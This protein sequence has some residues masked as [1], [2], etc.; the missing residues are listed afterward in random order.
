MKGWVCGRSVEQAGKDPAESV[1][2]DLLV[3]L[4][5]VLEDRPGE[6]RDD[7]GAGARCKRGRAK[8]CTARLRDRKSHMRKAAMLRNM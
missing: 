7:E 2:V 1:P 4:E 8:F 6:Q 5:V 3:L